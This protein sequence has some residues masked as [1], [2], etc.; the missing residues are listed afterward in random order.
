MEA[1]A[2]DGEAVGRCPFC[3]EEATLTRCEWKPFP[4]LSVTR[5]L[6]RECADAFTVEVTK[7]EA[8]VIQSCRRQYNRWERVYTMNRDFERRQPK[9]PGV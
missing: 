4:L 2:G 3:K 6:C 5:T 8:S 9:L 7:I 1:T